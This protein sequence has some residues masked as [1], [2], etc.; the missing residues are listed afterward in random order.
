[1]L[2]AQLAQGG[3]RAEQ[4]LRRRAA[5]GDDEPRPHQGELRVEVLA[6]VGRLLRLG[7]AVARRPALYYVCDINIF[8]FESTSREDAV[9]QLPRRPDERLAEAVLVRPRR[10]A[11]EAQ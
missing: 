2:A 3:G 1:E 5:E 4:V 7:R 9:E 11:D 8:T 6:A 10:L